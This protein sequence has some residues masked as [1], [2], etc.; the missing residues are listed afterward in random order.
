MNLTRPQL[1]VLI[2]LLS[3]LLVAIFLNGIFYGMGLYSDSMMLKLHG[4]YIFLMAPRILF[5]ALTDWFKEAKR[6]D[7]AR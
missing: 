1:F 3:Y 5:L 7:E 2:E 4:I 6:I